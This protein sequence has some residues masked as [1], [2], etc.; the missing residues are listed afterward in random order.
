MLNQGRC[1]GDQRV[2]EVARTVGLT[3]ATVVG[4]ECGIQVGGGE[5][6]NMGWGWSEF[7]ALVGLIA[8]TNPKPVCPPAIIAKLCQ[9]NLQA[10]RARNL[11]DRENRH[12]EHTVSKL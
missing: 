12:N 9:T 10:P 8:V 5:S 1:Q 7:E 11:R 3:L 2:K 6:V 4:E